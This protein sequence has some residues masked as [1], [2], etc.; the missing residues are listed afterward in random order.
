MCYLVAS[1]AGMPALVKLFFEKCLP[2]NHN[3]STVSSYH[4]H[5]RV[6]LMC[7]PKKVT[8]L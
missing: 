7:R 1:T 6:A 4:F 8:V 2:T 3:L 5:M